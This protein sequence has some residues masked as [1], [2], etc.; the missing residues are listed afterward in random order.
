MDPRPGCAEFTAEFF[1]ESSRAWMENKV[2]KGAM[3]L[4][5][6]SYVHSTSRKCSKAASVCGYCKSHYIVMRKRKTTET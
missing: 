2:R 6:C 3:T 4:Y 5:R 1:D